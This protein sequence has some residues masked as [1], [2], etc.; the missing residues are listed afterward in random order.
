MN[1]LKKCSAFGKLL[2]L[3]FFSVVMAHQKMKFIFSSHFFYIFMSTFLG[4]YTSVTIFLNT[5][6]TALVCKLSNDHV[7]I[8]QYNPLYCRVYNRHVLIGQFV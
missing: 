8:R 2:K 7:L 3:I 5:Y 1:F 6:E 4:I